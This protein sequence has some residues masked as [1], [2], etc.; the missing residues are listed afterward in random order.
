[1]AGPAVRARLAAAVLGPPAYGKNRDAICRGRSCAA[2]NAARPLPGDDRKMPDLDCRVARPRW[3]GGTVGSCACRDRLATPTRSLAG[4]GHPRL[5]PGQ[6][7]RGVLRQ[8]GHLQAGAPPLLMTC[9]PVS[10][11]C[12]SLLLVVAV[13]LSLV[14]L[15]W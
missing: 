14:F 3:C 2:G 11:V 15:A 9:Q 8:P 4:A 6:C 7:K 1:M 10:A 13:F 12:G 5:G